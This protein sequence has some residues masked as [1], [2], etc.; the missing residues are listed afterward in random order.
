M[1]KK[2]E[3]H[4]M[5]SINFRFIKNEHKNVSQTVEFLCEQIYIY[6]FFFLRLNVHRTGDKMAS[7]VDDSR[8]ACNEHSICCVVAFRTFQPFTNHLFNTITQS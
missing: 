7:G 4:R 1:F 8:I 3:N 2:N 5:H 6:I